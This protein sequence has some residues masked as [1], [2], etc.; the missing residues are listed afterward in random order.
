MKKETDQGNPDS[1][2]FL[3]PHFI[4]L[5]NKKKEE[6]GE[7]RRRRKEGEEDKNGKE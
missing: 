2:Y 6:E 7:R 1:V 4:Q 3:I 5:K